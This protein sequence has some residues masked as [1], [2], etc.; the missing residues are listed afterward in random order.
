M[1]AD[2][3]EYNLLKENAKANRHNM[4]EAESA[5][6]S[7]VR[8]GALGERCIRQH[9]IGDYIVDFLFR[10]SKLIVEIDGGYHNKRPSKSPC[11][12]RLPESRKT[13]E[14]DL[15][16]LGV[17]QPKW[18]DPTHDQVEEDRVRQDWLEHMGY[19]VIRFTNKQ[20]LCDTENVI[21]EVKASLN[22]EVGGSSG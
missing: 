14:I 1:T 22:W 12:G 6:W 15:L 20:V 7:M 3:F 18:M 9:V 13:S 2:A 4:T 10:K 17:K 8:G 16:E 11:L 21:K 5:F 19:K